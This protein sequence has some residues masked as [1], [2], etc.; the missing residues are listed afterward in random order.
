MKNIGIIGGT[1][2]IGLNLL[3]TLL[4]KDYNIS[5]FNRGVTTPQ[6]D[7]PS[8]VKWFKG[9]RKKPKQMK[10]FFNQKY[11]AIIDFS[12]Y[13]TFH[14]KPMFDLYKN[15]IGQY[16][17][18]S[19]VSAL[20]V[21]LP[22]NFEENHPRIKT[23]GTYG[24]DKSLVEDLLLE[25]RNK[26][27]FP[28]TIFRPQGVFGKFGATHQIT[29]SISRLNNNLPLL[30]DNE[31]KNKLLSPLYVQD[32]VNA[33][34]LSI[35]NKKAFGQIYN[36]GGKDA[37]TQKD[38]INIC[39]KILNKK[40]KIKYIEGF[41]KYNIGMPWQNHN[42][43][44]SNNKIKKDL[45]IEFTPLYDALDQTY[46]WMKNHPKF[47]QPQNTH[48]E[49]FFLQNKPIPKSEFI[50]WKLQDIRA[51]LRKKAT[52]FIKQNYH[53]YKITKGIESLLT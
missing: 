24:G 9:D 14:V 49:K 43:V 4:E 30:I 19:S 37:V 50:K 3:Y 26:E 6:K 13:S 8:Q 31:K 36:I 46:N 53:I 18:V 32:F 51:S 12:A 33:I 45:N 42:I 17:F 23:R 35:N 21:P 29:Y 39:S 41:T 40:P 1:R 22:I 15:K 44:P 16:I 48:R 7:I 2:F 27:N 47:L 28:I 20:S 52:Q 34:I 38:Y 25:Y 10:D 11:D 5:I